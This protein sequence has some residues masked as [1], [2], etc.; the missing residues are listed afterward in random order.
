MRLD[1]VFVLRGLIASILATACANAFAQSLPTLGD[2]FISSGSTANYSTSPTINVGGAGNYE[3]LISFDLSALPAG[4]TS[5]RIAKASITLFVNKLGAPGAI[6]VSAA[7]GNWSE[8]TVNGTNAPSPGMVVASQVAVTGASSY[9]TLDATALVQAW[10]SG[11]ITNSGILIA[12]DSSYPGTSVLFDSKESSS[13]S[14]P[15]VLQV[16]LIGSGAQ[17]PAGPAG[18]QGP[19]GPQGPTGAAGPVGPAGPAASIPANL[20]AFSNV[21]S[22]TGAPSSSP[23]VGT[24]SCTTGDIVLSTNNYSESNGAKFGGHYLPANGNSFLATQ[25]SSLYSAIGTRFG[26]FVTQGPTPIQIFTLPNLTAAAPAGLYYS[27]CAN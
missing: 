18:A 15:A 21:L 7:N 14:H 25:F 13:T 8:G 23:V 17:G 4:T 24:Q 10:L 16:T 6:D 19:A 20:T 26:G 27:I 1:S 2:T 22:S 11:T 5:A 12:A 3:G 9:I